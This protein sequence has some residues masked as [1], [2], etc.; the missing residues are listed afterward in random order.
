MTMTMERCW[1][2][3]EHD[4]DVKNDPDV[5][6][7][8]VLDC[9]ECKRDIPYELDTSKIKDK[10]LLALIQGWRLAMYDVASRGGNIGTVDVRA[11]VRA[12]TKRFHC[13]IDRGATYKFFDTMV[14]MLYT[15]QWLKRLEKKE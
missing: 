7:R 2:A 13:S 4:K 11:L 1:L 15:E 6:N 8:R 3:D 5:I 12:M 9:L 10:Q 14:I